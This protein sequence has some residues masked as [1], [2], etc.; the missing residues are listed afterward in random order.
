MKTK[1]TPGP[2]K[3]IECAVYRSDNGDKVADTWLAKP[4]V[5]A[6][7]ANARL[8]AAAPDL[9]E[10]ARE[11]NKALCHHGLGEDPALMMLQAAIAKAEGK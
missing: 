9:L 1:H 7:K 8:I 3:A 6:K 2:W 11:A 4:S 5:G 10:A